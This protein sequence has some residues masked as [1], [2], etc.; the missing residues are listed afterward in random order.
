ME[1]GDASRSD[2]SGQFAVAVPPG[3]VTLDV[4]A[5]GFGFR[6]IEVASAME[7]PERIALEPLARLVSL[8]GVTRKDGEPASG[9]TVSVVPIP[10]AGLELSD[11]TNPL[12]SVIA[13]PST[14]SL[15]G[16]VYRMD[17]VPWPP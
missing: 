4:A 10:R 6:R 12:T 16:G 5:V 7:F 13:A 8:T 14:V 2:G 11:H 1:H 15:S 9:V 3:R 17:R